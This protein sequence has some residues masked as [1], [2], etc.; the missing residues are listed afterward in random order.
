MNM[1]HHISIIIN[2][3]YH[4]TSNQ[5]HQIS[6]F[7]ECLICSIILAVI[8]QFPRLFD[9]FHHI[10]III[11]LFNHLISKSIRNHRLRWSNTPALQ[12]VFCHH[13]VIC[14]GCPIGI[15]AAKSYELSDCTILSYF[16]R[17]NFQFSTRL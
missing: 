8:Y 7:L 4:L 15:I 14:R 10:S 16:I 17:F 11:N 13:I 1:F 2:L 6:I 12:Q 3:T 5:I 9:M